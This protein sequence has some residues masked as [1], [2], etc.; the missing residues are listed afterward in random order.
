MMPV[1]CY[2]YGDCK[3]NEGG[4]CYNKEA[5]E[6]CERTQNLIKVFDKY[7]ELIEKNKTPK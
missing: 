1:K 3:H 7:E 6:D 4:L 5:R 2:K